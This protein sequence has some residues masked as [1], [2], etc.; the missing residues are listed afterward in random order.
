MKKK[1]V[2]GLGALAVVVAAGAAWAQGPGGRHFMHGVSL[3]QRIAKMEDYVQATPQ[4]RQ[5]I[6]AEVK[7]IVDIVKAQ[8]QNGGKNVHQ[9]MMQLLTGDSLSADDVTS[10]AKQH[11]DQM[12]ALA[13]QIAPHIVKVHDTLTQ[14]QRQKL[15]EKLQQMHQKHQAPQGGF[16]GPGE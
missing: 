14:A 11:A 1:I 5:Q 12:Q 7:Q 8:R 10:L 3:T 6:D 15:A 4:Q 9:Q 16:G 2:I 13:A